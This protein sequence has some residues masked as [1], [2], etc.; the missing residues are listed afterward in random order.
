MTMTFTEA[1]TLQYK[2]AETHPHL[3]VSIKKVGADNSDEWVC[4][5]EAI[6]YYLWNHND[7]VSYKMKREKYLERYTEEGRMIANEKRKQT[8]AQT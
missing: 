1:Q 4:F 5:I 6:C 3:E 2:I 8:I 7:W